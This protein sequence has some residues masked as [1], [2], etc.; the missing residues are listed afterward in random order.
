MNS[1]TG[2][3]LLIAGIAAAATVAT[4]RDVT[5]RRNLRPDPERYNAA[6]GDTLAD[7]TPEVVILNPGD[8]DAFGYAK[9]LR[10]T[11][12]AFFLRNNLSDTLGTLSLRLTYLDMDGRTLHTR[13]V[14]LQEL[15]PARDTRRYEI[16]AWDRL[17]TLYYVENPPSRRAR[18]ATPYT[19]TITP[20]SASQSK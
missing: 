7:P 17:Q 1:L 16:R 15:L 20:L 12:E 11:R 10:A 6:A 18:T 19:V 3:L 13:E 9:P 14:T 2:R 4:A 8:V 5:T